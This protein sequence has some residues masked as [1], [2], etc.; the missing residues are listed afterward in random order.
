LLIESGLIESE[1]I[2]SEPTDGRAEPAPASARLWLVRHAQASFGSANYD[3]LSERGEQQAVRLAQWLVS[4]PALRFA[5]VV[6]GALR[7]HTQT[8]AP[9]AQAFAAV[10]RALPEAVHDPDWNEF[11]HEA[12]I[13]AWAAAHGDDPLLAAARNASDRRSI[14]A[15][16]AAALHAWAD[17][18]LD[19]TVPETWSEFGMRVARARARVDALPRGKVLVISSGGPIAR[20]AQ[21]ALGCDA[22]RA[23][24]L[25]LALRNSAI[26]E[27]RSSRGGWD[28]QIWNMLP[29]LSAAA[30]RGWVTYY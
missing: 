20:C 6:T 17:G 3:Q 21:F 10:G 29:H 12:V 30:D 22:Q 28:L 18:E 24:Q 7:R 11:Q 23:V 13:R 1:S 9:L 26:S 8:L 16:L 14:H 15:L 27:F 4:D 2:E 19:G 5:H 25:N